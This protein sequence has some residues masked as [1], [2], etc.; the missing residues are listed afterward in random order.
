MYVLVC[1]ETP[2]V[3]PISHTCQ[4]RVVFNVQFDTLLNQD[5]NAG[6]VAEHD[7]VVQHGCAVGLALTR[8]VGRG[9][10]T[11][12]TTEQAKKVGVTRLDIPL[13]QVSEHLFQLGLRQVIREL[14]RLF[15]WKDLIIVV[16]ADADELGLGISRCGALD[17]GLAD[18][19]HIAILGA[20]DRDHA[21]GE[22]LAND[23][24]VVLLANGA[25][26]WL[27]TFD[28]QRQVRVDQGRGH[29]RF[30]SPF[31]DRTWVVVG[32]I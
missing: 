24:D 9:G 25:G 29:G 10:Q 21:P 18:L 28:S 16:N 5:L 6:L 31:L 12:D 7:R 2:L 17:V 13:D 1:L 8:N 19:D 3:D 20:K 23:D 27:E 11:R 4:S 32:C 22:A 26:L 14:V 30:L 15:R